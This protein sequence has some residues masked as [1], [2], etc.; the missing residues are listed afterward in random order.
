MDWMS[1]DHV[2]TLRDKNATMVQQHR[3]DVFY[4]VRADIARVWNNKFSLQF[5]AGL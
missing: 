4:V 1:S 3:N 5:Q 2:G